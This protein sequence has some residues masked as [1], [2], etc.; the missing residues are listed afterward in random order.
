MMLEAMV[1]RLVYLSNDE[2]DSTKME[3]FYE[4]CRILPIAYLR[5]AISRHNAEIMSLER[6]LIPKVMF[7]EGKRSI[8]F[9]DG[10]K[11]EIKSDLSAS[12]KDAD[13]FLLKQWLKGH[14]YDSIVKEK[15]YL[16][17]DELTV[18]QKETLEEAGIQLDSE[19]DCHTGS[20]K[21]AIKEIFDECGDL[22][23]EQVTKVKFYDQ[24]VIRSKK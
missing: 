19:L 9:L 3:D 16:D 20:F 14:G 22:P 5:E 17:M 4:R 8:E 7:D 24:A 12:L 23:P 11:I 15:C 10:S 2:L 1:S 6:N 13:L 21:K 18:D